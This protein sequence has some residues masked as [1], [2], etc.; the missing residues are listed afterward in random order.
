MLDG[1]RVESIIP[2]LIPLI[3]SFYRIAFLKFGWH[4]KLNHSLTHLAAKVVKFSYVEETREQNS[5]VHRFCVL[6]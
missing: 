5:T 2:G 3:I 6:S 1:R 4:S